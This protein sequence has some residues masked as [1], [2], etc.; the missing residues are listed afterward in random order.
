[1]RCDENAYYLT[2]CV[3][4]WH[5]ETLFDERTWSETVSRDFT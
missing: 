2:A 5:G 4:A 3:R 1:M